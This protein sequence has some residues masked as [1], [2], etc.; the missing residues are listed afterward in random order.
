MV[1]GTLALVFAASAQAQEEGNDSTD[2][3]VIQECVDQCT[4]SSLSPLRVLVLSAV[5][6][7][8]GFA[9]VALVPLECSAENVVR[10]DLGESL[11][12]SEAGRREFDPSLL[13]LPIGAMV[14]MVAT[15][16]LRVCAMSVCFPLRRSDGQAPSL[17][18]RR[19][20]TQSS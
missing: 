12:T 2:P 1:A 8:W 16:V 18:G 4:V 10:T 3:D 13:L 6:L 7:L 20:S 15:G 17:S 5:V 19:F 14:V 11:C 9:H